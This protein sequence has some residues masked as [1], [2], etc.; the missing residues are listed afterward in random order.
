[1]ATASHKTNTALTNVRVFDGQN[2]T[3]STTIYIE[4]GFIVDQVE[5]AVIID[6]Q[7][8]VLLPGLIDAHVHLHHTGHLR[9]LTEWGVTTGLDMATWPADKMNGL[10]KH[11]GLTDIRSAGLPATISGSLHSHM[12]PL[13][14][15]AFLSGPEDAP[16]FVKDRI[17]EGS[18]YIKII[19]D[20]PG[21]SQ[22]TMNAL[23]QEAHKHGKMAIAHASAFIPF[24]MAQE[25]HTD[26]I[27]HSPRDKVV[28]NQMVARMLQSNCIS[29][30]TLTMMRAVSQPP[31][32]GAVLGLL[33]KPTILW[34]IIQAKRRSGGTEKYENS[35][36]SVTAMYHAG[37]PIL[38][39]SDC[40]DEP[41]SPFDVSHGKSLHLEL[42]LLVEA[43]LSNVDALRA[44]TSMPAEYFGLADRGVI[45]VGKRADLVLIGG[46]PLQNISATRDI[47]KV[48]CGGIKFENE[49]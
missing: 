6:C 7:G 21:P 2:L 13:T 17:D 5:G 37:I 45:E 4:N 14:E 39:G 18:D 44:A 11:D 41:N 20:V 12:M 3:E 10:R 23:V 30:P 24:Q 36:D 34:A 29:V 9:Q 8:G 28:D 16:K 1:M 31:S 35:R 42:E 40:H 48:W 49:Q 32:L 27:T 26:I 25:A 43:G 38:A 22:E 15:S 47:R 46:D 33:Y 19:S